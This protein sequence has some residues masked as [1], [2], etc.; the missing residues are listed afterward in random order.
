MHNDFSITGHDL[1]VQQIADAIAT[2][3]AQVGL[4]ETAAAAC[5]A[6]RRQV[7]AWLGDEAPVVYGVNTALGNLKDTVLSPSEHIA[8]NSTIPYP[9]AVGM[10][11]F[12]NPVITRTALLIRANVLS[13]GYSGVRPALV[14]RLLDI[15]NAGISPAIRELGSTGLS[16]LGP[17]AH[18]AMV[19]SGME[20]ARVFYQ[21]KLIA[22][23]E[24][25]TLAGLE[26]RF[27][28]ECKE[29]LAIMNGSTMTQAAAALCINGAG[30]LLS[31]LEPIETA[32]L[33]AFPD[34][35]ELLRFNGSVAAVFAKIK[36]TIGFETNITCDNPLLF[37]NGN[38]YDVAMGCNCSNTQVGY[39][40]DLL[41]ILLSDKAAF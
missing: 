15:F 39:D 21:G 4:D 30:N 32:Q 33:A 13:R 10:G 36:R 22:A 23:R 29:V 17:M 27:T 41:A 8:W 26:P 6:S 5:H 3:S 38:T 16:D 12:I 24:A 25:L 2:N 31:Y 37:S 28:L 14:R 18:C 35:E 9:H 19:A 1:T 40:L 34:A 20:G 7:E 11:H